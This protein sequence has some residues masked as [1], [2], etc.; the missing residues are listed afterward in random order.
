[1][2]KNSVRNLVL[3]SL[4]IA[5]G[6]VL[7]FLTGQIPEIGRMLLPMHI[8]VLLAGFVCGG[9]LGLLV[10]FITPLLRSVLFGIP[11]MFPIA[12]S[13]AFELAVYGLLAGLLYRMMPKKPIYLWVVLLLSMIGGRVVWGAV[14][15]VLY[16]FQGTPF[17]WQMFM[18]GAIINAIPGI[19]LQIVAIP[20][21]LL[22]LK[23]AGLW[24][25]EK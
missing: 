6:L 4:F 12:V 21:I 16:G 22:A 23:K 18:G 1:M 10:G 3:A 20:A 24:R 7:P 17:T 11:V 19:I 15:M 14:S 2:R 13:M 8:P 25:D 9:P 5:L